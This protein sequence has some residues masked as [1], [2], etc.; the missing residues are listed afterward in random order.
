MAYSRTVIGSNQ[1]APRGELHGAAAGRIDDLNL[2]AVAKGH[3]AVFVKG[4]E[5][6]LLR[7]VQRLFA[8][9]GLERSR[10]A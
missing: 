6:E 9:R 1:R 8:L 7:H 4:G 2:G 5:R 3:F 10:P